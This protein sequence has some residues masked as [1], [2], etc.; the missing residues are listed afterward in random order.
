MEAI[1]MHFRS[2]GLSLAYETLG[3]GPPVILVHGFASH[4]AVNWK[5]TG[6]LEA[7]SKSGYRAVAY[8]ARGHGESDKPRDMAAYRLERHAGDLAALMDHLRIAQAPLIGYSMGARIVL[9][10]LLEEPE[11]V[12][13]AVL[14][15]LGLPER[16]PA[17]VEAVARAL[18]APDPAS[19]ADPLA[20][21]FRS[22][23]ERHKGDLLALA[24][25]FRGVH[26][27]LDLSHAASVAAPVLVVVGAKDDHVMRPEALAAAIPRA[28]L[29]TI[30]DRDHMTVVGDPRFKDAVLAFLSE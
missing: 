14:G 10:L 20:A 19:V 15:G 21:R 27:K 5:G 2:Q 25:C 29:V 1:V 8:D 4:R 17:F 13:K 12:T 22:F 9:K 30:P 23:A 7:L 11:R 28:R 16:D 3:E 26:E 6:W 18:E 24:A